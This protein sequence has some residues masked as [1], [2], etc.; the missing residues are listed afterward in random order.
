MSWKRA[1]K[2]EKRELSL[3]HRVF[4][5]EWGGWGGRR[6]G[7]GQP[8][9]D[10]SVEAFR[11]DGISDCLSERPIFPNRNFVIHTQPP[12]TNPALW[13]CEGLWS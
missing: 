6:S 9:P 1:R 13:G 8:S 4:T 2:E 11:F 7:E 10:I 5:L 12:P 3:F